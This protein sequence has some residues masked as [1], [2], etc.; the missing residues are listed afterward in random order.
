M[1]K[2]SFNDLA[3]NLKVLA[4]KLNIGAKTILVMKKFILMLASALLLTVAYGQPRQFHSQNHRETHQVFPRNPDNHRKFHGKTPFRPI[5]CDREWQKLPNGCHVRLWAGSVRICK[6]GGD[7]LLSGDEVWLLPSGYYSVRE[8]GSWRIYDP[9][10]E[11]LFGLSSDSPIRQ[12]PNGYFIYK[13]LGGSYRVADKK[14]EDVFGLSGDE[15]VYMGDGI[16]RVKWAGS[17]RYY[18]EKGDKID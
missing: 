9:W 15:I 4:R 14:G 16:F 7:K 12:Q 17:Y 5:R 13:T 8:M 1:Y 18:D 3:N 2:K 6:P 11:R 10:G